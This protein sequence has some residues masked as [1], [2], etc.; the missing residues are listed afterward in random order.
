MGSKGDTGMV[1]GEGI[2]G[3]EGMV[4]AGIAG[5]LGAGRVSGVGI[6]VAAGM[7]VE[8]EGIVVAAG[9]GLEDGN[10]EPEIVGREVEAGLARR[11]TAGCVSMT[12]GR[13]RSGMPAAM[14]LPDEVLAEFMVLPEF[15]VLAEELKPPPELKLLPL[16]PTERHSPSTAA[17]ANPELAVEV[18]MVREPSPEDPEIVLLIGI[19]SSVPERADCEPALEEKVEPLEEK[20]EPPP[21]TL[22]HSP[23]G[24][25]DAAGLAVT[26]PPEVIEAEG[27][28]ET[29]EDGPP[30]EE[31]EPP[32]EEE[33]PPMDDEPP[34]EDVPPTLRH[35]PSAGIG[36]GMAGAAGMAGM[37]E[38]A[39]LLEKVL[40]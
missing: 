2:V 13:S 6:V 36:S 35:C 11:V 20:E 32:K 19:V 15:I 26:D 14:E 21:P 40:S 27:K 29:E 23:S 31:E 30:K 25:A 28:E 7:V 10:D 39:E 38:M 16:L 34:K 12:G 17:G 37:S 9:M 5:N 1:G 8:T 18:D 24:T 3:A 33:E 4:V 22:R